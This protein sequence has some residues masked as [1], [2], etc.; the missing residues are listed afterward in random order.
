MVSHPPSLCPVTSQQLISIR[1]SFDNPSRLLSP[2]LLCLAGALH[3]VSYIHVLNSFNIRRFLFKYIYIAQGRH[4]VEMLYPDLNNCT[5]YPS[6]VHYFCQRLQANLHVNQ[7]V[8]AQSCISPNFGE[9]ATMRGII[10]IKNK[11]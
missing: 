7:V 9:K 5:L 2:A 11:K 8:L 4:T 3:P 6:D 1:V 10:K